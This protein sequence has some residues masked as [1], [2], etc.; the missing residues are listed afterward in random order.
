[1]LR[2]VTRIHQNPSTSGEVA[3]AQDSFNRR[4]DRGRTVALEQGGNPFCTPQI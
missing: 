3:L 1:M 4:A 2:I